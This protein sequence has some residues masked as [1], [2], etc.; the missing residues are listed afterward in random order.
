MMTYLC[1]K[2]GLDLQAA[3][4]VGGLA[5]LVSEW[6]RRRPELHPMLN[7]L[8]GDFETDR[9]EYVK[10]SAVYWPEELNVPLLILHGSADNRCHPEP[11]ARFAETL[12]ELGKRTRFV[13]YPEGDHGLT[14]FE[15]ERDRE[16]FDWFDHFR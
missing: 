14:N 16:I 6:D 10:R 9:E 13:C 2:H 11:V 3:A 5:D 15:Q 7:A 1:I 4:V 12:Q 8:I